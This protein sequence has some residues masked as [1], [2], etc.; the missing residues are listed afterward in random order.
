MKC[1]AATFIT[2]RLLWL[3]EMATH[4]RRNT[5]RTFRIGYV[6]ENSDSGRICYR[7]F[8]E[9]ALEDPYTSA[10]LEAR[11]CLLQ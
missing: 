3:N 11:I 7:S 4:G 9:K 8:S 2:P 5:M 10:I 6:K 1:A